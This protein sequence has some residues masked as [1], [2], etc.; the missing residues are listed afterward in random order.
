M[1]R[2]P[3]AGRLF[4]SITL[5]TPRIREGNSP[6]HRS[7][8]KS[9]WPMLVRDINHSLNKVSRRAII[10]PTLFWKEHQMGLYRERRCFQSFGSMQESLRPSLRIREY[11]E[12]CSSRQPPAGSLVAVKY[13]LITSEELAQVMGRGFCQAAEH[14]SEG[15]GSSPARRSRRR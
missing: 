11:I 2:M 13:M 9:D 14:L 8:I 1:V 12:T 7:P 4:T 6:G 15:Y 10:K 5:P 3:K